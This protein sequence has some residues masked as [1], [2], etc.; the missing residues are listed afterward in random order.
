MVDD[1]FAP[2]GSGGAVITAEGELDDDARR[3]EQEHVEAPT[4]DELR[5]GLPEPTSHP[6]EAELTTDEETELPG[7]RRNRYGEGWWGRGAPIMPAK[8]GVRRPFVDGAG[9]CSPG[10]WAVKHRRL[11]DDFVAKR[12]RKTLFDGLIECEGLMRKKFEGLDLKK[13]LM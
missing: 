6:L 12:L 4:K 10:R 3:L 13:L 8:K 9:L 2:R 1:W 5:L 11:P 7:Q